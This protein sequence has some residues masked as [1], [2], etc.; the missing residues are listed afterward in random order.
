MPERAETENEMTLEIM[1]R[2][3]ELVRGMGANARAR[4]V[5]SRRVEARGERR[6]V[7]APVLAMLAASRLRVALRGSPLRI[8]ATSEC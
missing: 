7:A 8:R 2:A 1:N 6:G 3:I 4:V 5:L